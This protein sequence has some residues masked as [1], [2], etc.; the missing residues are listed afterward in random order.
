MS[1]T[2]QAEPTPSQPSSPTLEVTQAPVQESPLMVTL[3][4]PVRKL[5]L[6]A[7][8]G[9]FFHKPLQAVLAVMAVLLPLA[10]LAMA[11]QIIEGAGGAVEYLCADYDENQ[12]KLKEDA[13]RDTLTEYERE[14]LQREIA[15]CESAREEASTP[16]IA[17][18]GVVLG[19]IGAGQA[20]LFRR[21][22]LAQASRGLF[23][24]TP[25]LS[26]VV[27]GFGESIAVSVGVAGFFA[28]VQ[29][30]T[31]GEESRDLPGVLEMFDGLGKGAMVGA[32]I[33]AFMI[34]L[35]THFIAEA[36]VAIVAIANHTAPRGK[37]DA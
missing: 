31:M 24:V 37:S 36:M 12:A 25:I 27:R 26:H 10:S 20:L 22:R 6:A 19:G 21:G 23:P 1:D 28:G 9:S 7:E 29:L 30:L 33:A 15:R 35:V 5:L 32:P 14:S 16:W 18:V 4:S 3:T 17:I 34:I 8:D 2:P 11:N 13:E